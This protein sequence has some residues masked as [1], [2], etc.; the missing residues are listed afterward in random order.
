MR[1]SIRYRLGEDDLA[2]EL[3]AQREH[4]QLR[5]D[6]TGLG[7]EPELGRGMHLAAGSEQRGVGDPVLVRD[8]L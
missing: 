4:R 8:G 1:E 3:V 7:G 2:L 6:L 5:E